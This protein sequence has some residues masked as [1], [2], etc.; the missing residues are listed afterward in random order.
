MIH[1]VSLSL[2]FLWLHSTVLTVWRSQH[3]FIVSISELI[4][5]FLMNFLKFPREVWLHLFGG[6]V[7]SSHAYYLQTNALICSDVVDARWFGG[8][9]VP[10]SSFDVQDCSMLKLLGGRSVNVVSV[11]STDT[12]TETCQVGIADLAIILK[13]KA[14]WRTT[15]S[16]VPSDVKLPCMSKKYLWVS[17]ELNRFSLASLHFA[18][19]FSLIW[20]SHLVILYRCNGTLRLT[21][22]Q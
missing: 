15:A 11:T 14:A 16:T 19:S 4:L 6:L 8:S 21:M 17:K 10:A 7:D 3:G 20:Q 2:P 12:Q 1:K 18:D 9:T 5:S 22:S 13:R